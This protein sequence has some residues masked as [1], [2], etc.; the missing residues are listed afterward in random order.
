M[1]AQRL[2]ACADSLKAVSDNDIS[3]CEAMKNFT[4]CFLRETRMYTQNSSDENLQALKSFTQ[5]ELS[6][7]GV[8]CEIDIA[9]LIEEARE[10]E[11]LGV[12]SVTT[13]PKGEH[14]VVWDL[15][16]PITDNLAG[17]YLLLSHLLS[18]R[19]VPVITNYR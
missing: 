3:A 15:V 18:Y 19:L 4:K 12:E 7:K 16:S 17:L 5:G 8:K 9:A 14:Y 2:G 6:K 10:E 11:E 13:P 1:N